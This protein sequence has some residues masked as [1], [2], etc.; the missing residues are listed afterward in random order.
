MARALAGACAQH[1]PVP[2]HFFARKGADCLGKFAGEAERSLRLLFEEVRTASSPYGKSDHDT[3]D[4]AE[5][6]GVKG[7]LLLKGFWQEILA[8][9]LAISMR[10]NNSL[11]SGCSQSPLDHFSG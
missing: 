5:I 1:S 10:A 3:F 6:R 8:L 9:R 2:I 4:V 11:I 7:Y